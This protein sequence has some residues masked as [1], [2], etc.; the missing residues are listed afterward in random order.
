MHPIYVN[1]EILK[2]DTTS[3]YH[4]TKTKLNFFATWF[5]GG[6]ALMLYLGSTSILPLVC[7]LTPLVALKYDRT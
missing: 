7:V 3:I 6:A 5:V 2:R 1:P 4:Y